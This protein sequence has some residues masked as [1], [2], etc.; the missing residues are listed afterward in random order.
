MRIGVQTRKPDVVLVV[1]GEGPELGWR[2]VSSLVQEDALVE[3]KGREGAVAN[4]VI[5]SISASMRARV[6]EYRP[7]AAVVASIAHALNSSKRL[8][9]SRVLPVCPLF[10]RLLA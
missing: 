10:I 9:D 7:G 1:A 8:L 6:K 2:V 3:K 4:L 5:N